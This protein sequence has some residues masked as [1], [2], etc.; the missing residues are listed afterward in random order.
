M[1]PRSRKFAMA[2]VAAAVVA[3]L[4]FSLAP[5]SPQAAPAPAASRAV[6]AVQTVLPQ[7]ADWPRELTANGALAAWQEGVVSA[8]T[9]GLRVT[10]L[11]A[12]VGD[13][14]KRGQLLAELA[15]DSVEADLRKY[16]AALASSQASLAQASA[17]AARARQVK[18]SGALSDQQVNEYLIAERTAL[19]SVAQASAQLD[20]QKIVLAHTRILAVDDG[21]ISSRSATLGK[22]ASSG[23]EMFRLVRQN[24]IEWR[25]EL[26]ARQLAEVRSGQSASLTLPDG[27]TVSG[28]VRVAAPTLAS[29]TSRAY[30]YVSL[31]VASPA[32]A[33]MYAS[34][35]IEVGS[36]P[37]LS[38]PQSAVVLRDGRSYVFEVGADSRVLRRSVTIG[39]RQGD[40]VEIVS[41]ISDAARVV[42]SGAAF[43]ADGDKVSLAKE[44]A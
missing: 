8:E 14:V 23:E 5:R 25:A 19:A 37:A 12:D 13:V 20:A 38:V 35:R 33:G 42:A 18:G 6:M 1:N 40:R 41:G 31:P 36:R 22:V 7:R 2:G 29:D 32:R 21:A 34:G 17:N 3:V 28:R 11:H 4:A 24:R 30:V 39:R 43:L 44:K 27:G 26:D 16:Q 10:A 9:G 15:R